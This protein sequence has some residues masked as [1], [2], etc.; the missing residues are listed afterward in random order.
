MGMGMGMGM[1]PPPPLPLPKIASNAEDPA[2]ST[3]ADSPGTASTR[4]AYSLAASEASGGEPLARLSRK[5]SK[6]L[7]R[8]SP[9]WF[10]GDG[11]RL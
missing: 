2:A 9:F 4:G 1:A 3:H 10:G 11:D 8:A 7:S 5:R 6:K